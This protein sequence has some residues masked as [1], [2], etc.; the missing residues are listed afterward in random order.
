MLP[1]EGS[2]IDMNTLLASSQS[3]QVL[4]I[5]KVRG[6]SG[7]RRCL[8]EKINENQKDPKFD[9]QPGQLKKLFFYDSQSEIFVE[10]YLQ[11]GYS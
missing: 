4:T 5:F 9:A 11:S 2:N 6:R 10:L 8:R 3:I 1:A 7:R